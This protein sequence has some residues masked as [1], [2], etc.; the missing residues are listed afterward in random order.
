MYIQCH[1]EHGLLLPRP[2]TISHYTGNFTEL[3]GNNANIAE[4][5][6]A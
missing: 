1:F 3:A 2:P 5:I 4:L 6:A